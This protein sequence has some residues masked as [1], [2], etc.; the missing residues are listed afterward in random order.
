MKIAISLLSAL[1]MWIPRAFAQ[2]SIN[3]D[4]AANEGDGTQIVVPPRKPAPAAPTDLR[5]SAAASDSAGVEIDADACR[6]VT[7]HVPSP[8]T[9]YV[10]GVD[11]N[12]NPVAPAGLA[13]SAQ[14]KF[15]STV[16]IEVTSNLARMLGRPAPASGTTLGTGYRADALVGMVSLVEGRLYFNGQPIGDDPDIELAALC[17][18]AAR[19]QKGEAR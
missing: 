10:G 13:P 4:A 2:D 8:D 17:R 11:A 5:P 12:G 15:P 7:Q 18:N 19:N 6:Y 14:L 1:L 3:P 9:D 16:V